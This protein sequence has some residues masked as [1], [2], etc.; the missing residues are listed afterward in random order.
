M[1]EAVADAESAGEHTPHLLA[2]SLT[3]AVQSPARLREVLDGP[4]VMQFGE[5]T[6]AA[7]AA[8]AAAAAALVV[9]KE[10]LVPQNSE[11][12]LRKG[13]FYASVAWVVRPS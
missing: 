6:A 4:C 11:R 7:V 9:G 12:V 3:F 10:L 13:S 2:R 8:A 5:D 1:D